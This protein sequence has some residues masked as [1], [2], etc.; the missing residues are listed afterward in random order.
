MSTPK[1]KIKNKHVYYVPYK[2]VILYKRP[3]REFYLHFD[4]VGEF[5]FYKR[6]KLLSDNRGYKLHLHKPLLGWRVDFCLEGDFTKIKSILG[7]AGSKTTLWIEYKGVIH[8]SLKSKIPIISRFGVLVV[9]PE[10][11]P[12]ANKQKYNI[13]SV[14][15]LME[16]LKN[17]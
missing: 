3:D 5:E 8:Y 4:S 6:L 9:V 16:I 11:S 7:L 15:T 13:M 2:D 1:Y 10:L 12:I 14:S 17:V